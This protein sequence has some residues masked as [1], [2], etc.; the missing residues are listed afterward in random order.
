MQVLDGDDE[1]SGAVSDTCRI[2]Q[3]VCDELGAGRRQPTLG[4]GRV[5]VRRPSA[6]LTALRA[7]ESGSTTENGDMEREAQHPADIDRRALPAW[8]SGEVD[9]PFE[10]FGMD[11]LVQRETAWEPHS[12]PWHELLWNARGASSVT[13]GHRTWTVT[14]A[15]GFWVP[16]GTV[17]TGYAPEGTWYRSSH[18]AVD[19]VVPFADEPVAVE[20]TPLLALL[21]ERLADRALA[22]RSRDLTQQ[23]ACDL[24]TPSPHALLVHAPTA[25]LLAPIVTALQA[26]P[27]DPRRLAEWATELGVSARTITRAMHAETGTGFAAWHATFRA[28]RASMLLAGGVSVEDTADLV[29][30]GSASA[31]GAAFRRTTG[32]TPG[33]LRPA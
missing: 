26:D 30:Y 22:P 17:H 29:G 28:Q 24:L 1:L 5:D 3:N 23:L 10:I 6:D 20:V 33:Q 9:M 11:E 21:L 2:Q 15:V 7:S 27:G 25:P 4:L 16:A 32:L 18:F 19:T 31:F 12:H 13:I 8:A 14:P